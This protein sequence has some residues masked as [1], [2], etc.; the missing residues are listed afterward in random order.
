V[1][2][3]TPTGDVASLR[4]LFVFL[5]VG[6][7]NRDVTTIYQHGTVVSGQQLRVSA[8]DGPSL[9]CSMRGSKVYRFNR[10]KNPTH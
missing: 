2:F 9:F 4:R 3:S 8:N 1:T 5:N 10:L 7:R 6:E